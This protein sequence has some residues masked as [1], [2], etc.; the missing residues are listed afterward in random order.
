[1]TTRA[2]LL[3]CVVVFGTALQG[4]ELSDDEAAAYWAAWRFA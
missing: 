4:E 1:M 2:L 3:V